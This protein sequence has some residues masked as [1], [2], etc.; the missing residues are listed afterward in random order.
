MSENTSNSFRKRRILLI[1]GTV[2]LVFA[3]ILYAWSILKVPFNTEFGW[4]NAQLATSYTITIS[5]FCLGCIVGGFLMRAVG[6][7]IPIIIGGIMV[8]AG[9]FLTS[10]LDGGN[11]V[12]LYIYY[13]VLAGGGIGMAYNTILASVGAWFPE[14]KG[15]CSGVLMM[16]FGAS[17]LVLGNICGSLMS[18]PAFGWRK[19]F[20]VLAIAAG[21]AMIIMGFI[22][23]L[24]GPD[25]GLPKP[26]VAANTKGEDFE[27]VD[28]PT[29]EMIK[30][31][32]FWKFFIAMSVLGAAGSSLISFARD[33]SI[34]V[35]ASVAMAG[36]FVGVLSIA[37][38]LGRILAGSLYDKYGREFIMLYV[39]I[40]EIVASA[41][42]LFAAIT[43]SI[44][45]CLIGFICV[46]LSY[47]GN[48]NAV[49]VIIT[50]FYGPKYYPQNLS[51]GL[52]SMLPGAILAKV[53]TTILISTGGYV[54]P[55]VLLIV[56]GIIA[57]ILNVTNKRP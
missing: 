21:V 9:F 36:I 23:E 43:G 29:G 34:S 56:Y 8:F 40:M 48:T 28:L 13:G 22:A 32:S 41:L 44:A 33:F 35:G 19:V 18:N 17:T 1:V 11:I 46:G 24:P 10:T 38:G 3:G 57:T 12:F 2:G 30:R 5:M 55:F 45:I 6:P 26:K 20:V 52:L 16:G 54:V 14:K 47:G 50:S 53:S 42:C 51:F 25:A 39:G 37:N 4:E 31:L 27:L 15:F 7:K 49:S